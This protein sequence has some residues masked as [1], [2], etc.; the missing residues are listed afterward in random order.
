ME[1][2]G[3]FRIRNFSRPLYTL[4]IDIEQWL[5][6]SSIYIIRAC[7]SSSSSAPEKR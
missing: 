6:Q 5:A 7:E 1:M 3:G 2:A 4:R